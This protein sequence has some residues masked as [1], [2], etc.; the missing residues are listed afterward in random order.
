M[1][2]L[3]ALISFA[4]KHHTFPMSKVKPCIL[5][6]E[7]FDPSSLTQ[8][9]LELNDQTCKV[10]MFRATAS[11]E[12]M[13]HMVDKF[14]KFQPDYSFNLLTC[15][16]GLKMCWTPLQKI[17]ESTKSRTSLLQLEHAIAFLSK[18]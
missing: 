16:I 7:K 4:E 13:F 14:L 6:E 2:V 3:R 1:W 15:R 10:P 8:V 18:K 5:Y 17:D 11:V 9:K 12:G